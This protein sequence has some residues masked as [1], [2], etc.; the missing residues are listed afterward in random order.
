VA[1][2][3]DTAHEALNGGLPDLA[4][5]AIWPHLCMVNLKNAFWQRANG[6]EAA[7]A[8]WRMYWT[9][10]PHGLA[11]WP[12]VIEELKRRAYEGVVCLTAEY[13]DQTIVERLAAEDLVFA[14][15]LFEI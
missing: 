9:S 11:D 5:D 1:A 7:H 8:E 3:W 12:R 4:L 6:P 13:S 2:V 15:S 10:G 14:K